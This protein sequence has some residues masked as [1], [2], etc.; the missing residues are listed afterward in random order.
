MGLFAAQPT[1]LHL[2]VCRHAG[3][4][5]LG[6]GWCC[7]SARPAHGH[8]LPAA[9][10]KSNPQKALGKVLGGRK[11]LYFREEKKNPN[12]AK[13]SQSS[14]R[15]NGHLQPWGARSWG[16]VWDRILVLAP[17]RGRVWRKHKKH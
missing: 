11:K 14:C 17:Q 3:L 15:G 2:D 10:P 8:R 16:Q 5:T 4:G 6:R 12:K 9:D 13:H 7:G 1:G